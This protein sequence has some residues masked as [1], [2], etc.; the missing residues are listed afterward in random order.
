MR[1]PTLPQTEIDAGMQPPNTATI[2]V[3]EPEPERIIVYATR[4][5]A[6]TGESGVVYWNP[7][8]VKTER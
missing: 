7:R 6:A 4:W 2:I 5:I 8:A 1:G 3:P